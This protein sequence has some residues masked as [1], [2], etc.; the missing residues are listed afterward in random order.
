M[1][2][3]K[4]LDL[5]SAILVFI[6]ALNWGLVGAF[7]F[8]LV[9]S[10]FGSVSNVAVH[11]IYVIVGLFGIYHFLRDLKGFCANSCKSSD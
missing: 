2:H 3:C 9:H 10:I 6:G 7:H 8:N 5:L 11:V 4:A 1:K